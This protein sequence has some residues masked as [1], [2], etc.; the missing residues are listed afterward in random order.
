MIKDGKIMRN[1]KISVIVPVYNVEKYLRRCVD[2]ILAQTFTDFELLLIDDGSTDK[3]GEI[4]DEYGQMD[5]RVRVFHQENGGVSKARNVGLD[6]AEGEWVT[7]IDSDDYISDS[8]FACISKATE[9]L[10]ILQCKHFV[11]DEIFSNEQFKIMPQKCYGEENVKNFICQHMLY[12]IMLTPWGKMFKKNKIGKIRFNVSQ[13]LGEDVI[14]V[15]QYLLFCCS[16]NVISDAIYY[17]YDNDGCFEL[18]Y[19]MFPQE[20]LLHLKNI[21]CQYRK[22]NV[23][24]PQFEAFELGLFLSICK[25]NLIGCSGIW[26]DDPFVRDLIAS[27][28]RTLGIRKYIKYQLF[29]IPLFYNFYVGK[30]C[31]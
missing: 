30:S 17:Y 27:C 26:F 28:K 29:R 1:P 13:K 19:K 24:C 6:H 5:G 16:L 18:K 8:Y 14:F 9:D 15:H 11:D 23:Y 12:Q 25:K 7:F 3:S 4:C 20:S 10:V 31:K 2:S 22:L 21:V